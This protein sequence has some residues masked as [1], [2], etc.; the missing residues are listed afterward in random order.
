MSVFPDVRLRKRNFLTGKPNLFFL[1]ENCEVRIGDQTLIIPKG[2][3]T[4]FASVPRILWAIF[5][6]HGR[7]ATPAV[8]HDYMYDKRIGEAYFGQK[9]ARRK[10]DRLFLKNCIAAHVPAWQAVMVYY[11]IRI[12]AKKWWID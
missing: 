12:F 8:L 1:S 3:A 4:D 2:Y 5:P 9:R 6:P 11:A 10:A 7:M